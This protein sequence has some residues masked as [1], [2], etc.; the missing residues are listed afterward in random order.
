MENGSADAMMQANTAMSE[1]ADTIGGNLSTL[2]SH[3]NEMVEQRVQEQETLFSRNRIFSVVMMIGTLLAFL[4]A[5]VVIMRVVVLP[6]KKQ[7]G[8]LA[9]MIQEIEDG[10]GDLTKRI[11]VRSEDELGQ[12]SAGMN[13]FIETLQNIMSKIISNWDVLDGVVSNVA[14]SVAVSGDNAN[15][16]SAIMEE[17]SAAMEEVSATTNNVSDNTVSAENKVQ[18]MAEQT[19][20]M[21]QYAQEMNQALENSESVKKVAQ[22][23]EDILSIS[24]QT[25]LLALNASTEAARAGAAGKGF[26]VVA[27]EIG[28]LAD[29]SRETANIGTIHLYGK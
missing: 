29:S 12:F 1:W 6:V 27:D 14:G 2:A 5:A 21:T 17:L 7:R 8:E 20:V 11:T 25:N 24:S 16:I 23:T 19:K 3:N 4:G 26:A 18:K 10:R 22:L 28:Q 15:D 13:H 9:V